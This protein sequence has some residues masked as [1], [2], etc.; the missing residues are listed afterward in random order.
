MDEDEIA[1]LKIHH[2]PLGRFPRSLEDRGEGEN[3]RM[4]IIYIL[5]CGKEGPQMEPST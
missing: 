3:P 2:L 1:H 4:K 5:E